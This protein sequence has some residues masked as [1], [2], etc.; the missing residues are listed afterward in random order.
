MKTVLWGD[1][2]RWNYSDPA[3]PNGPPYTFYT[4][5]TLKEAFQA[6]LILIAIHKLVMLIVKIATSAEFRTMNNLM[7]KCLHVIQ[8]LS[9]ATPYQDWDEG[10]HT[11]PEYKRRFRRTNIEMACC[12]SLNIL[13]SLV[14]IMPLWYTGE[15]INV[16]ISSLNTLTRLQDP[17]ASQFPDPATGCDQARGECL[18]HQHHQPG[19][20]SHCLHHPLQSGGGHHVLSLQL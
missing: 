12:L 16:P 8:N 6:F 13:V 7:K 10:V 19:H 17:R 9:L 18:L 3:V 4:Y 1:L 14:M 5:L 15:S 20:S 2:D 11:I